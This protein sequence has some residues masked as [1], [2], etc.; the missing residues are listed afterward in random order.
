MNKCCAFILT[1]L[2]LACQYARADAPDCGDCEVPND[3]YERANGGPPCVRAPCSVKTNEQQCIAA[4]LV[5]GQIVSASGP[6]CLENPPQKKTLCATVNG[7][8]ASP[9]RI[10]SSTTFENSLCCPSTGATN[11]VYGDISYSWSITGPTNAVGEGPT[12][13]IETDQPGVYSVQFNIRT[14]NEVCGVASTVI[15]T[16]LYV[17]R[18]DMDIDVDDDG[19]VDDTDESKEESPGA[20][21][22]ENWDNDD[23]D[24]A[25]TPDKDETSVTG[26]N[27]LVPFYPK[28][29]PTLTTGTLKL[30]ATAG[31]SRVK[32][33]MSAT[34]GTEVTLPKTWDLAT[35]TVPTTLYL[36][37]YDES[38]SANDV[39]LKLSYANGSSSICDDKLKITVVRQNFGVAV[40]RD[41]DMPWPW[42][43]LGHAG[44]IT[45]YTGKRTKVFLTNESNWVTT[46]MGT[47]GIHTSDLQTFIAT[48]PPFRGS[49]S[50]ANLADVRRNE[51]LRNAH[52]CLTEAIA[53]LWGDAISWDGPTW[54]GTIPDINELR[55]DGL[56]EVCYELAAIEVWGMNGTHYPIQTWPAEHQ[57]LGM[58]D[59]QTE[60]S[61][62]V[63]R[64]GVANSP[65]RFIADVLFQPQTLP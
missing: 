65:T 22:F 52:D 30:E 10:K 25:H 24:A 39:E 63:Q 45:G 11:T 50:V 55:C 37:G 46:E 61:P 7:W 64:G 4:G 12:A 44:L 28:L 51:I 20:I 47:A 48:R 29:E 34:K 27:D 23:G 38:A 19:D 16:N 42:T 57:D 5:T 53:Y 2:M 15:N 43:P 54:D 26:E 18:V 13:C 40:Y 1:A 3:P 59:P 35:E 41:L 60:L 14:S 49:C 6:E 32:V 17:I 56:V 21:V 36:E 8:M 62:V 33:W 31:G 9:N 58:D